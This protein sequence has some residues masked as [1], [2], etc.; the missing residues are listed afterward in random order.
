[1]KTPI[2]FCYSF[3][4]QNFHLNENRAYEIVGKYM[5]LWQCILFCSLQI[6]AYSEDDMLGIEPLELRFPFELN[7]QIS[8]SLELTNETNAYIAFSIQTT[9]PLPFH[10]QPN[11]EIVSPQSKY[12]INIT[13]QPIDKA[14][15]DKLPGD[16][17]V[18]S[19]K[20]NDHLK[21][22]DLSEDI[23]K[24]EE[25]KL[26]DEVNLTVAYKAEIP[27]VDESLRSPIISDTRNLHGQQEST[28]L[29]TEADSMVST[30]T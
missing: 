30:L 23:F 3:N 2:T 7:N 15:Q 10:I 22:E 19:T 26:V 21:S 4:S 5:S 13:L 6:N 16:F 28:V 25:G 8:C 27:Q 14:P 11:K 1:M 17:I 20:V 24:K 18:R 12:S 29:Q 9:I